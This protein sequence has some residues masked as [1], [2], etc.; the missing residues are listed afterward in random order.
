MIEY[1]LACN[2]DANT[3]VWL[4]VEMSFKHKTDLMSLSSADNTNCIFKFILYFNFKIIHSIQ[5]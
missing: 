2:Y 1:Y 5:S 4:F 3:P